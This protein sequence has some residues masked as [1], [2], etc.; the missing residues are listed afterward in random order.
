MGWVF[1]VFPLIILSV[2]GWVTILETEWVKMALFGVL[3]LIIFEAMGWVKMVVIGAATLSVI[4]IG[5]LVNAMSKGSTS[6]ISP[7]PRSYPR[8]STSST[9]SYIEPIPEP[10]G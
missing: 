7:K 2:M 9:S 4:G 1:E 8:G 3:P 6:S 10:Q 5:Y